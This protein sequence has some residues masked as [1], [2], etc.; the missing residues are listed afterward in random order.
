MNRQLVRSSARDFKTCWL[1]ITGCMLLAIPTAIAQAQPPAVGK[2]SLPSGAA[3]QNSDGGRSGGLQ[4]PSSLSQES[5]FKVELDKQL[6]GEISRDSSVIDLKQYKTTVDFIPLNDRMELTYR[7]AGVEFHSPSLSKSPATGE[8]YEAISM[9][10]K[11]V[12][13]TYQ[14]TSKSADKEELHRLATKLTS[15]LFQI[16]QQARK[17]ELNELTQRI[18]KL[19]QSIAR[20]EEQSETIIA[21]RV[22][23]ML[24]LDDEQDFVLPLAPRQ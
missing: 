1:L 24:Q 15:Y 8:L 12:T 21:K 19:K 16:Q 18:E 5:L 9:V 23:Q 10:L 22:S 3:P 17:A 6:L 11:D 2:G 7:V 4:P 20:R 13:N 14:T